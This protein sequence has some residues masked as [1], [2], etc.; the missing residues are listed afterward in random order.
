MEKVEIGKIYCHFKGFEVEILNIALDSETLEKIIV[1][2]HN[3][4]DE[5]WT[6]PEKMFFES[7]STNRKDNITGQSVR[8][9]LI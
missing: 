1:Y 8:F 7:V 9:K 6:R 5:I 2:K 4:T 3:G